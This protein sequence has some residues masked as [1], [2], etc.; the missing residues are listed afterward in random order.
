ME[1]APPL[2][3]INKKEEYEMKEIRKHQ[4]RE[5][6]TQFLVYWKVEGL[7]RWTWLVDYRNRIASYKKG[8]W[9]LLDKNFKSKSIKKGS[10]NPDQ[11]F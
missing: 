1:L 11:Q 2:D 6:E 7:W 3:I 5:W 10:K 9:R 4:K 8:D